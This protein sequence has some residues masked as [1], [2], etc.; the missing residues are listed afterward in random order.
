M[1]RLI[2]VYTLQGI[3]SYEFQLCK[4]NLG[5][6]HIA[7]C[8][9]KHSLNLKQDVHKLHM[10][11][12]RGAAHRRRLFLQSAQPKICGLQNSLTQMIA[13]TAFA[14]NNPLLISIKY[15]KFACS[16]FLVKMIFDLKTRAREIKSLIF[17]IKFIWITTCSNKKN[18]QVTD[19]N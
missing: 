2:F 7:R 1:T 16:D 6:N 5:V 11:I 14:L 18:V 12:S 3:G 8:A 10:Q 9:I 15:F 13:A 4:G 19:P 17:Q